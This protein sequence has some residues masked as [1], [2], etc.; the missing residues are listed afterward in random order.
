MFAESGVAF[1][2]SEK[3][4]S[5]FC[6]ERANFLTIHTLRWDGQM[7]DDAVILVQFFGDGKIN[8]RQ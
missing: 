2:L 5:A 7:D 4:R 8:G 3:T 6:M 1:H